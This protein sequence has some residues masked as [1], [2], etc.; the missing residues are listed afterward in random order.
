M[1]SYLIREHDNKSI[2]NDL[3]IGSKHTLELGKSVKRAWKVQVFI[4]S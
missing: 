2:N 3:G 4:R 1:N